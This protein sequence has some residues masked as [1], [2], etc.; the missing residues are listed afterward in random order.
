MGTHIATKIV[1]EIV[2]STVIESTTEQVT[3]G[4]DIEMTDDGIGVGVGVEAVVE[5]ET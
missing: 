3:G 5:V 1:I 2:G 4:T